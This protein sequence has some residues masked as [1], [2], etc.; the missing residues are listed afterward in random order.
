MIVIFDDCD[1]ENIPEYKVGCFA[2]GERYTVMGNGCMIHTSWLSSYE[3]TKVSQQ[4]RG[5][6]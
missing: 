5:A 4:I 6:G 2:C 1:L 3:P